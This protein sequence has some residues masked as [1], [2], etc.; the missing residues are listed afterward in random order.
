MRLE[1]SDAGLV[2]DTDFPCAAADG[3]RQIQSGVYGV[4]YRREDVVEW[5]Q[6]LLDDGLGV[7]KEYAACVRV[8]NTGSVE[9]PVRCRFLLPPGNGRNYL[10]PPWW[11]RDVWGWETI[12]DSQTAAGA[13]REY[14][15]LAVRVPPEGSI[16]VGSAPFLDPDTVCRWA[17]RL[18]EQ[19][20]FWRYDEIG[21]S[22]QGRPI[23]LL[24]SPDR[25]VKLVLSA[26]AQTAEPVS[27]GVLHVA[28][29]LTLPTAR[30]RR[31]LERVQFCLLPL[32]NPDGAAEG[33]SLT[34]ALG[35]VPKFSWHLVA[36]GE[37]S[38][39]ETRALWDYMDRLRPDVEAEVHAH[40]SHWERFRRTAGADVPDAVPLPLREKARLLEAA[41]RRGYP[42]MLPENGMSM[43]DVR[44]PEHRIYGNH[45]FHE[46]GILR[47]FLQAVP[48][49]LD[50]HRADVRN[51]AETVADA[52]LEW[53]KE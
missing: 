22:A 9:K 23:P 39:S 17:K 47:A 33:R 35:E 50:A 29:W 51:F 30:T 14:V 43:I 40:H 3:I 15:E 34:N 20:E 42:G 44:R 52:L 2:L 46:L 7:P 37:T 19:S 53:K 18:A 41:L 4:E 8:S 31:L 36:A 11:V 1:D 27:W 45:C 12:P 16:L 10:A 28:E 21:R 26:T 13:H 6:R 24:E 32:T 48:A 25:P 5:F 38:P 49:G